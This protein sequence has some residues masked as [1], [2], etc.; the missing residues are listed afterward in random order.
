MTLKIPHSKL[1][2]H[3]MDAMFE[4]S[5]FSDLSLEFI[6]PFLPFSMRFDVHR[7]ILCQSPFFN[8]L[9]KS[10]TCY[11][12]TMSH[13]TT[14]L[15]THLT[16]DL[17][18]AFS[19]RGFILS[20]FQHIVTRK[21]QDPTDTHP[22]N[23]TP[24][25]GS[26]P[27]LASHLRFAL[28]WLYAY[29]PAQLLDHLN[30]TDT[31]RVLSI[32]ILFDMTDLANNCVDKYCTTQL[33]LANII[34]DLEIIGQ[35]PRN[36]DTYL[37]LRDAVLL[38]LFR[39][40]PNHPS[41][42]ASLPVD[43]MADVLSADLLFIPNEF[44]RYCL[45][46]EVLVAF[47]HSVGKITWTPRG[48]V[49]QYNKRLSGFVQVPFGRDKK[50][51]QGSFSSSTAP[52]PMENPLSATVVRSLKRKRIPSQEL[53]G[54]ETF[55][56][57]REV[58]KV[59]ERI[60]FSAC[61]PF[62]KLKADAS[63]GG[64]ID[65]ATV[66][67]Y[68]LKTTI[69]Y[70]NMTFDQ[71]TTVRHDGIVEEGVVFR[72]LW[73]REALERIIFPLHF[74]SPSVETVAGPLGDEDDPRHERREA[75]DDYFDVD[76]TADQEH[77]RRILLGV[78]R[79]RF[80]ASVMITPASTEHGWVCVE[81][82][83]E[84]EK[85]EALAVNRE[86][87][88]LEEMLASLEEEENDKEASLFVAD[89]THT[90]EEQEALYTTTED[91]SVG[92]QPLLQPLSQPLPQPL[93]Q[94]LL[95]KDMTYKTYACTF[96]SQPEKVL[97][98]SY[99]ISTKAQVMPRHHWHSLSNREK[100]GVEKNEAT[101]TILVCQFELQRSAVST[102]EPKDALSR[103]PH[104]EIRRET[105]QEE[106]EEPTESL[107]IRRSL[108][109]SR[110]APKNALFSRRE[111]S[112]ACVFDTVFA[113]KSQQ[114]LASSSHTS[115]TPASQSISSTPNV[116]YSI[117]C[118]GRHAPPVIN[119]VDKEDRVLVPVTNSVGMNG[120]Q[121]SSGTGYVE[122]VVVETDTEQGTTIDVTVAL[123]MFGFPV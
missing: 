48:P 29:N 35:L 96:Y 59:S 87:E 83:T 119:N 62:E 104:K 109:T 74:L 123:E 93:P 45:L 84:T 112:S 98:I 99:R 44:A 41:Y 106:G 69:N 34:N 75:L 49:D 71:L 13:P 26:S 77:R 65:K 97:G 56:L 85:K 68:L 24:K 120:D 89:T 55:K 105:T 36:H 43:Y 5:L 38:L 8:Q 7:A 70:S 60:S 39:Q 63:S 79:F 102:E 53:V 110:I 117:Y 32:A 64:V 47:M 27:L 94:P 113:T 116:R 9:M 12:N 19:Q 66:L 92:R 11:G 57:N 80:S 37:R 103:R 31:L 100:E 107:F 40:G 108:G 1:E 25:L 4:K 46:K 115:A 15:V 33:S 90:N 17:F 122:Q 95:Q 21:S 2:H 78:P 118:L 101:D 18:N 52:F 28:Q 51:G 23:K 6:H 16:I 114:E 121:S 50:Q 76:N 82:S 58:K 10:K 54:A 30:D 88:E 111:S 42:L 81:H 61:V 22:S 20:P 67:S 86:K 91:H 73:Q 14:P 72:A 3:L